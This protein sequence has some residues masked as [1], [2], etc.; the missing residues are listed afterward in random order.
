MSR[1]VVPTEN[2]CAFDSRFN[3]LPHLR[4]ES[5]RREFR[6]R[7]RGTSLVRAIIVPSFFPARRD[8]K[9]WFATR[10][11]GGTGEEGKGDD[12]PFDAT[13]GWC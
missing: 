5:E 13:R 1:A 3:T 7:W 10:G 6:L 12:A 8:K 4:F 11:K 2:Y 9:E